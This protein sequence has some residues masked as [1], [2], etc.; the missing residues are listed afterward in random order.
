MASV[1]ITTPN[2]TTEIVVTPSVD[3]MS[4]L[5]PALIAAVPA[6]LESFMKCLAGPPTTDEYNP[7]DRTRCSAEQNPR[8]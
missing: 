6:F 8:S 7:G 4:C 1:I 2:L 5:F 3:F